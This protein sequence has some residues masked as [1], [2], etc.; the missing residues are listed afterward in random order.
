MPV[1]IRFAAKVGDQAFKCGEQYAKLGKASTSA[2]PA[3]LRFYVQDLKLITKEGRAVP[4]Q[5][6]TRAP[7]QSADVALLDFE[8]AT[9]SCS[10]DAQTNDSIT[11]RVAKGAYNAI[12]FSNGVPIALN[13][14]DPKQFPAPLKSP[15]MSWNWLLG[16]RFMKVELQAEGASAE[17]AGPAVATGGAL[18]LGSTACSGN[19]AAGQISCKKPNRNSVL[20]TDYTLDERVI[21]LD[22]A[23]IFSDSDLAQGAECHA[24]TAVCEGMFQSLGVDY[25]SGSAAN[26]QSAYH[27]QPR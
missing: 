7:F 4:V 1:T 19:P 26:A 20:L 13:H 6:D 16:L 17:D 22:V 3:D 9:G 12:R 25:A 5:I 18:H 10:G 14:A 24:A 2:T 11:G 21:V 23:K 8:D 27:L 15:G